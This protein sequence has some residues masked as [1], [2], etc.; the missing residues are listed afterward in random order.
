VILKSTIHGTVP[1]D[2][3]LIIVN[4]ITL[5]GSRCGRFEAAMPLLEQASIRLDEMVAARYPLRE[6]PAA[7]ARAA[8]P[9]SL[10]VLLF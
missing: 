2:T 6:A 8:E 9:G 3:A 10:K 1:L 7:F 5:V 4:E